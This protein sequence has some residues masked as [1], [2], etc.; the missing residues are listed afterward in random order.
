MFN[1]NLEIDASGLR[2][3]VFTGPAI[4]K[5]NLKAAEIPLNAGVDVNTDIL[6]HFS[7]HIGLLPTVHCLLKYKIDLNVRNNSNETAVMVA[8][9]AG[10]PKLLQ[11]LLEAGAD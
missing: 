2:L 3:R 4:V 1:R 5:G 11:I 7:V 8:V 9:R 6:L 10:E